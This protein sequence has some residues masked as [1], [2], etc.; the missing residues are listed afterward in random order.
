M[1]DT[2]KHFVDKRVKEILDALH[3]CDCTCSPISGCA[4]RL[5][6]FITKLVESG[7]IPPTPYDPKFGDDRMCLCN[8]PYYRHF[9][10]YENMYPIGCKYCDCAGFI[11]KPETA[12]LEC[13][14]RPDCP[15]HPTLGSYHDTL[16]MKCNQ[17]LR[18]HSGQRSGCPSRNR[19]TTEP[20]MLGFLASPPMVAVM[21]RKSKKDMVYTFL[22][23]PHHVQVKIGREFNLTP[24]N[25]K[26]H[27]TETFQKW[28]AEMRERNLFPQLLE[29]MVDFNRSIGRE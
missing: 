28:F 29:K 21:D 19:T 6:A 10:T 7:H 20:G 4:E 22:N 1:E 23:L 26:E 13:T 11:E 3:G 18:E 9:D 5:K 15:A 8:H 24:M 12:P 25:D 27:E 14:G 17:P 16:C 2:L